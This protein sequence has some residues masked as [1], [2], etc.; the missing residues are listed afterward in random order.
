MRGRFTNS[1]KIT[2]DRVSSVGVRKPRK[3]KTRRGLSGGKCFRGDIFRLKKLGWLSA[4][5]Q[6]RG[7]VRENKTG[8]I[9]EERGPSIKSRVFLSDGA[10]RFR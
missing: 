6:R 3:P 7:G 5:V 10:R 1:S 9:K 4:D 2:L 8:E